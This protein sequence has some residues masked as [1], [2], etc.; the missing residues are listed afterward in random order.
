MSGVVSFY[1]AH[2]LEIRD[3]QHRNRS[4]IGANIFGMMSLLDRRPYGCSVVIHIS[5]SASRLLV[6]DVLKNWKKD[7]S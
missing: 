4:F 6:C 5:V 2:V 3:S 7:F 1:R